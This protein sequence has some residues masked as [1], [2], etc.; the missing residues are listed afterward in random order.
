MWWAGIPESSAMAVYLSFFVQPVDG[1]WFWTQTAQECIL[2]IERRLEIHFLIWRAVP[3]LERL[4]CLPYFFS[5]FPSQPTVPSSRFSIFSFSSLLLLFLSSVS[6]GTVSRHGDKRRPVRE[7]G[8]FQE[9]IQQQSYV[10]VHAAFREEFQSDPTGF[11][12]R[13]W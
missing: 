12:I 4:P 1:S 8:M 5:P 10:L 3:C 2:P 7:S 11:C 6:P 9:E 13:R